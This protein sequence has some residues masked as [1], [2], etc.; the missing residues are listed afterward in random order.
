MGF[1]NANPIDCNN[2]YALNRVRTPF[3]SISIDL[4]KECCMFMARQ[5]TILCA[6]LQN[7]DPQVQ[8]TLTNMTS[9]YVSFSFIA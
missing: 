7:Y 8:L 6:H 1:I 3:F 4:L 5:K 9:I 2:S